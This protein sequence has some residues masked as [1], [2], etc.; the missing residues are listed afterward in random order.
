MSSVA[1]IQ[2]LGNISIQLSTTLFRL[3]VSQYVAHVQKLR[4]LDPDSLSEATGKSETAAEKPFFALPVAPTTFTTSKVVS[5]TYPISDMTHK[6]PVI[7]WFIKEYDKMVLAAWT[8]PMKILIGKPK[9][10]MFHAVVV[11]NEGKAAT[12]VPYEFKEV[13]NNASEVVGYRRA[14]RWDNPENSVKVKELFDR[15]SVVSAVITSNKLFVS[16]VCGEDDGEA[17]QI[18]PQSVMAAILPSLTVSTNAN[19]IKAVVFVV[20]RQADGN[21]K[22]L[23]LQVKKNLQINIVDNPVFQKEVSE[24]TDK[25]VLV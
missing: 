19:D 1:T 12:P 14:N 23:Q 11:L 9:A 20:Y 18:E 25:D 4:A 16:F 21:Y 22:G 5:M 15:Q 24:L 10:K 2:P 7:R 3:I 6:E 17:N 8:T 13:V